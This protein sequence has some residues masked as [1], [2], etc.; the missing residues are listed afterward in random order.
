VTAPAASLDAV[1]ALVAR[2]AGPSRTPADSG[3][4]T[5]LSE[6]GFWLDSVDLL[7][8]VV[9]CEEAFGIAF[10]ATRDLTRDAVE[11]LGTLAALIDGK[12]P[13]ARARP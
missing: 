2:V 8:V 7:E 10:D 4:D 5:P 13:P 12:R 3:P 6:G 1:R 9:G 11:T